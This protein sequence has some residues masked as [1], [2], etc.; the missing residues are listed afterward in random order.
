MSAD[1]LIKAIEAI[2]GRLTLKGEKIRYAIPEDHAGDLIEHLRDQK[3]AV[4]QILK[5]RE[6]SLPWPGYNGGRQFRSDL[7][8]AYFDTSA[9]IARHTVYGCTPTS[10]TH[11]TLSPTRILPACPK[12]GSFALYREKDGRLTCQTC[13]QPIAMNR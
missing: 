10:A 4:I 8:G 1:E 9:G 12:C 5:Q 11:S 2:G 7:C 6:A 13:S 3:P